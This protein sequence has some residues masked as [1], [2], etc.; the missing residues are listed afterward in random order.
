MIIKSAIHLTGQKQAWSYLKN[1]EKCAPIMRSI[2]F[3]LNL[4][5][6][7]IINLNLLLWTRTWMGRKCVKWL[8]KFL[9]L[10]P[11]FTTGCQLESQRDFVWN[12]VCS[13][14]PRNSSYWTVDGD[15]WRRLELWVL[16]VLLALLHISPGLLLSV[17]QFYCHKQPVL[18]NSEGECALPQ[19]IL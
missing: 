2:L 14:T 16:V 19:L 12:R 15:G 11:C 8:V 1:Q 13:F 3:Q 9:S 10:L 6:W 4:P 17:S 5:L 7:L 18:Y